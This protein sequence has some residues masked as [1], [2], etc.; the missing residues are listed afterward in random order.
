MSA[1][2]LECRIAQA[3]IARHLAGETLA[4]EVLA[5]LESHID[6]CPSCAA[7]L[8]RRRSA[9]QAVLAG[10]SSSN[11]PT[12]RKTRSRPKRTQ[13]DPTPEVA[14]QAEAL[15][16]IDPQDLEEFRRFMQQ[17]RAS[18]SARVAVQL[19]SAGRRRRWPGIDF[20]RSLKAQSRE[21]DLEPPRKP[22]LFVKP[23]VYSVALTGVLI[24]MSTLLRDPTALFG[25]RAIS[26]P[27]LA[28]GPADVPSP[29]VPSDASA[30]GPDS[31]TSSA[32]SV[33]DLVEAASLAAV[34]EA[35]E[36]VARSP[37]AP[38]AAVAP[39]N[40]P[41]AGDRETK[42]APAAAASESGPTPAPAPPSPA[43]ASQAAPKVAPAKP[44]PQAQNTRT[45]P[46]NRVAPRR[47]T[48]TMRVYDEHGRPIPA[49]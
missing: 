1:A 47:G 8:E 29:S 39:P 26:S 43:A 24:L 48:G 37:E 41:D 7:E 25:E 45:Q 23:L 44:R 36:A 34:E 17:K 33:P 30:P 9:L 19:P 18:E 14:E 5:D 4:P 38:D 3:Q 35:V 22:G 2:N 11:E 10:T 31:E 6:A 20:L 42:P 12:P 13:P 28:S 21:L 15:P 49:P 32:T 27:G 16:E 46:R 40:E